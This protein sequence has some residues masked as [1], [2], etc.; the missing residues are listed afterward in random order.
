MQ[1]SILACMLFQRD[2][3]FVEAG[4]LDGERS[5]N[6]LWLEEKR[7]WSGLLVEVDPFLYTQLR[8]KARR[9][10][11]LN[12]CLSGKL[13]QVSEEKEMGILTIVLITNQSYYYFYFHHHYYDYHDYD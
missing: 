5:S 2:L 8:G 6:T 4:G 13:E 7:G 10:Y 11:S 9:S 12:A 1:S 3:F